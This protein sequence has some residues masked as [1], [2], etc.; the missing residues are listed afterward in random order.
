MP[1]R[2]CVG[3]TLTGLGVSDVALW[4]ASEVQVKTLVHIAN[5]LLEVGFDLGELE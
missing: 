1:S 3:V 4:E 2:T 5:V